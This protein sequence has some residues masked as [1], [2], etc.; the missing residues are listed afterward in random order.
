MW[1]Y[2]ERRNGPQRQDRFLPSGWFSSAFSFYGPSCSTWKFLAS[3]SHPSCSWGLRHAAMATLDLSC[4]CDLYM[5]HGNTGALTHWARPGIEPLTPWTLCWGLN[6]LEPQWE[7]LFPHDFMERPGMFCGSRRES[8]RQNPPC[9]PLA[10][11][12]C[13]SAKSKASTQRPT[14]LRN[15]E[16]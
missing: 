10:P 13:P 16:N 11:L 15:K 1:R 12:W 6:A 4:I 7:G 3:G 9:C 14:A 8:K 2:H 5:A